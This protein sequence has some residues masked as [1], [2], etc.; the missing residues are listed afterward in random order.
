MTCMDVAGT[1]QARSVAGASRATRER[2]RKVR[3]NGEIVRD[4]DVPDIFEKLIEESGESEEIQRLAGKDQEQGRDDVRR[5]PLPPPKLADID[6]KPR[7]DV[8]A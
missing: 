4:P 1:P 3:R 8:E 7:L 2:E 5:Q 6:D